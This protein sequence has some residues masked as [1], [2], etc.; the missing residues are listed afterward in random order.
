MGDFPTPPPLVVVYLS[1]LDD[2][3]DDGKFSTVIGGPSS[4]LPPSV[5]YNT[6]FPLSKNFVKLFS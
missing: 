4:S 1:D 3:K 5:I 2:N 6:L